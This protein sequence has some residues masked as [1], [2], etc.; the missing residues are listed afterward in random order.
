M[1]AADTKTIRS[2]VETFDTPSGPAHRRAR[3][4]L[5]TIG[6]A[7]V[8]PLVEALSSPS[9][10][11]RWDA[12]R[13]LNRIGDPAAAPALVR[14]LDDDSFGV[15][16]LAAEGLAHMGPAA[17]VPLLQ[18]LAAHFNRSWMDSA[19]HVLRL[20][21]DTGVSGL[22]APVIAAIDDVEPEV[23][24]PVAAQEVLDK[25]EKWPGW[26]EEEGRTASGTPTA[27]SKSLSSGPST[28]SSS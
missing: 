9:E 10:H 2:L 20:L 13:T 12:A 6:S 14:A 16:W 24:V 11:V 19:H 1:P 3:E 28:D 25:L 26:A 7:A 22:L 21:E 4:R 8:G 23:E 5:A 27:I 18:E 17:L 15:R